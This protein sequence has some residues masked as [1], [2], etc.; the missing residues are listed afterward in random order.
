MGKNYKNESNTIIIYNRPYFTID[1]RPIANSS[2]LIVASTPL[3]FKILFQKFTKSNSKLMINFLTDQRLM[4]LVWAS[5]FNR[6]GN[7]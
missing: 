1:L 3:G 6:Y 7:K 4:D 2:Y 5:R